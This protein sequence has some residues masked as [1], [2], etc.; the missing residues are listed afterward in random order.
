[1]PLATHVDQAKVNDK[2]PS[3]TEVEVEA[4]VHRLRLHRAGGNMHLRT[5]HF[6]QRQQEA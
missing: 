2:I 4:A 6:K 1:M 5:E 3:E